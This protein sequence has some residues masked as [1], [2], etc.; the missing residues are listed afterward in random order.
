MTHDM[1]CRVTSSGVTHRV[2]HTPLR[3]TLTWHSELFE[4][5]ATKLGGERTHP[6]GVGVADARRSG[7]HV[8]NGLSPTNNLSG[9]SS[10]C[11]ARLCDPKAQKN[12]RASCWKCGRWIP[13]RRAGRISSPA[14]M[15]PPSAGDSDNPLRAEFHL[16][17]ALLLPW[18]NMHA[19]V[20]ETFLRT[21]PH[22][23]KNRG[24]WVIVMKNR[25]SVIR[26]TQTCVS[27]AKSKTCL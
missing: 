14:S 22:R 5:H 13:P 23:K 11:D 25:Q 15:E 6:I 17:S 24:K 2:G 19:C 10:P 7:L 3:T 20:R 16:L 26:M 12:Y 9:N 4:R 18:L 1:L 21:R 27:C 8:R